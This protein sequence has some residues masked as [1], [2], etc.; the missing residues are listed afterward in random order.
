MIL[1]EGRIDWQAFFAL[2]SRA[3]GVKSRMFRKEIRVVQLL[4]R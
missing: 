1:K 3:V 4:G 2:S